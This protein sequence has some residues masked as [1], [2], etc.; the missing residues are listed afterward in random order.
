MT[1]ATMT[2]T[3]A[4]TLQALAQWQCTIVRTVK[5]PG[6]ESYLHTVGTKNR[7]LGGVQYQACLKHSHHPLHKCTHLRGCED[8]QLFQCV[9]AMEWGQ[10]P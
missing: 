6:S 4:E 5:A 8:R 1:K 3:H 7:R 9:D 10:S 2:M